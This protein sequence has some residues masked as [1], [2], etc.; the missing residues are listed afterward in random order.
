MMVPMS[1]CETKRRKEVEAVAAVETVGVD[2]LA[3]TSH[4]TMSTYAFLEGIRDQ[5]T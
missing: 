3:L 1:L 5:V 4:V 2:G